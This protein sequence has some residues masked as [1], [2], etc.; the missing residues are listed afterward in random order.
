MTEDLML[1]KLKQLRKDL[2]GTSAEELI[3]MIE[4]HPVTDAVIKSYAVI[5][6]LVTILS[7]DK[8]V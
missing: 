7:K 3:K 2:E 1:E 4:E 6:Q 8:D 5:E